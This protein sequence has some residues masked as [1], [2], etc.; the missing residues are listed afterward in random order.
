MLN[1]QTF[2]A[3]LHNKILLIQYWNGSSDIFNFEITIYEFEFYRGR[4][5]HFKSCATVYFVL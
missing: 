2:I 5:L 4:I 1:S 3:L